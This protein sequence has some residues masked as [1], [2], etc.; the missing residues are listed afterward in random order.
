[1]LDKCVTF[2]GED[3][4]EDVTGED[5]RDEGAGKRKRY[6]N[7]LR[8]PGIPTAVWKKMSPIDKA[9]TIRLEKLHAG[10]GNA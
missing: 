7:T 4:A 9:E 6:A 2:E 5:A 1:M 3:V 10:K 8:P